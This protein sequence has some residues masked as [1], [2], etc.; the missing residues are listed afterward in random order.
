MQNNAVN[1]LSTFLLL[2]IPLPETA[3]ATVRVLFGLKQKAKTM[4]IFDKFKDIQDRIKKS[5]TPVETRK[6]QP[7]E[8][9]DVLHSSYERLAA[10]IKTKYGNRFRDGTK[11]ADV[12]AQLQ[13]IFRELETKGA[14][15]KYPKIAKGFRA[16]IDERK[17]G[18]LVRVSE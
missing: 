11:S 2:H 4:S 8:R 10:W 14:F 9:Q 7:S 1:Y 16:Y 18:D 6:E 17:Y 15:R 12:E 3:Q 5:T 13:N